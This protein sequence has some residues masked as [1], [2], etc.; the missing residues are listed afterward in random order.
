MFI[1]HTEGKSVSAA[2]SIKNNCSHLT[3]IYV[4]KNVQTNLILLNGDNCNNLPVRN[5]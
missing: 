4:K 1:K 2:E 3:Q 5:D